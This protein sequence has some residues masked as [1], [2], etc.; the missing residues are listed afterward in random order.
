MRSLYADDPDDPDFSDIEEILSP[1]PAAR[2]PG[3]RAVPSAS[4]GLTYNME[5]DIEE[6]DSPVLRRV[7]LLENKED[8]E[9]YESETVEMKCKGEL[10]ALRHQVRAP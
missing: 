6:L 8:L 3:T 9:L 7:M 5:S 10:L 4:Q 2:R 1:V